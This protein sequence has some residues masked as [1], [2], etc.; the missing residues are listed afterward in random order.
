M[1]MIKI[2]IILGVGLPGTIFGYLL[3]R[4]WV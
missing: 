4:P 3:D 2:N 1:V